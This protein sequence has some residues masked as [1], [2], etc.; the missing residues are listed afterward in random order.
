MCTPGLLQPR[1]FLLEMGLQGA[2]TL[3][4]EEHMPQGGSGWKKGL[5][6]MLS[7]VRTGWGA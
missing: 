4:L 1:P 6:L 5:P 3:P 7:G 2:A